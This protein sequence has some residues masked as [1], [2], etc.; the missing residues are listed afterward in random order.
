MGK[1][2]VKQ[3]LTTAKSTFSQY[4]VET[5]RQF[6]S[7]E[8]QFDKDTPR[9]IRLSKIEMAENQQSFLNVHQLYNATQTSSPLTFDSSPKP[10]PMVSQW[11]GF[12]S[13]MA[14]Q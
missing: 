9:A 1:Y 5:Q 10:R 3:N 8:R 6:I 7:E 2:D 4:D 14:I 11:G 12:K 13:I